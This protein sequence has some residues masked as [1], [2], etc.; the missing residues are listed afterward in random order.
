MVPKSWTSQVESGQIDTPFSKILA[1]AEA[2]HAGIALAQL[3]DPGDLLRRRGRQAHL[4]RS[5]ALVLEAAH[6]PQRNARTQRE[7]VSGL[8]PKGRAARRTTR[9]C[10]SY[11][12]TMSKRCRAAGLGAAVLRTRR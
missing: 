1:F 9:P 4:L 6:L 3:L 5:A 8:C 11:Q 10:S 7:T 2:V 12:R